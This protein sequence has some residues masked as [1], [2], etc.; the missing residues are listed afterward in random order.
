M[1]VFELH[2]ARL[3]QRPELFK[4]RIEVPAE[5]EYE[6]TAD[7]STVSPGVEVLVRVNRDEP[8]PF[9]IPFTKGFWK[10]SEPMRVK[11]TEGMNMIS[12]TARSPNRGVSFKGW[13]LKP[14]K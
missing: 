13:L 3:G 14:V 11:L 6:L 2:Y 7:V 5:G 9:A 8:A 4:Y 1:W 12:V 10:T